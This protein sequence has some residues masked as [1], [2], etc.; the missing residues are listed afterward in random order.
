MSIAARGC[1]LDETQPRAVLA[2]GLGKNLRIAGRDHD[3][4]L[5]DTGMERFLEDNLEHWL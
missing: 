4:Y 5:V 3:P 1:L 2:D